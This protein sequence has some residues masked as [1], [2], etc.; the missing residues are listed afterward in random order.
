MDNVPLILYLHI[1]DMIFVRNKN[2]NRKTLH[3]HISHRSSNARAKHLPFGNDSLLSIDRC[4]HISFAFQNSFATVY[5]P[6]YFC[7]ISSKQEWTN[8]PGVQTNENE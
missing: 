4:L 7:I 1:W 2:D 3:T 5:K 6:A 8:V